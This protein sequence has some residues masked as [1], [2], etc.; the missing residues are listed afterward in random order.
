MIKMKAKMI[1]GTE[2]F[3]Q[4]VKKRELATEYQS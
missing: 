2:G 3:D 4:N 1:I